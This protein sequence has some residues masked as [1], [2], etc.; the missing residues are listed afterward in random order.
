LGG[1][2]ARAAPHLIAAFAAAI[3]RVSAF[4]TG[5]PE[6]PPRRPAWIVK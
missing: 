1:L 3:D 4:F 5:R 6:I 2:E